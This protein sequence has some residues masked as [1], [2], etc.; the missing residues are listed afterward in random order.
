M[1]GMQ[2]QWLLDPSL[3]V[4]HMFEMQLNTVLERWVR[5]GKTRTPRTRPARA[6]GAAVIEQG[7]GTPQVA[8]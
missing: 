8:P 5:D 7:T 6:D 1:D 2:L 4:V 3:P